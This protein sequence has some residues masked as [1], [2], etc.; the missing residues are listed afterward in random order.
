MQAGCHLSLNAAKLLVEEPALAAL[1]RPLA[2]GHPPLMAAVP[3][4][5]DAAGAMHANM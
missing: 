3:R 1:P 4:E 5:T 2:S